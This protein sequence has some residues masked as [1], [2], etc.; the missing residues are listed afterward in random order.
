MRSVIHI[1]VT[2]LIVAVYNHNTFD[3]YNDRKEPCFAASS[4]PIPYLASYPRFNIHVVKQLQLQRLNGDLCFENPLPHRLDS[5]VPP[6]KE[7]KEDNIG[8]QMQHAGEESHL[9]MMQL[10]SSRLGLFCFPSL[11]RAHMISQLLQTCRQ[12]TLSHWPPNPYLM[13]ST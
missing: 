11:P 1:V 12:E 10:D 8:V 13:V 6:G 9:L 2:L 7:S 4:H 3:G 5:D